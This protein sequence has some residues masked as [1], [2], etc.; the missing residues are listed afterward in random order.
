MFILLKR[1]N[2]WTLQ[3]LRCC[4]LFGKQGRNLITIK[5]A[6]KSEQFDSVEPHSGTTSIILLAR[7]TG[8]IMP[9]ES[10]SV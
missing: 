1:K 2:L 10:F 7:N 5:P 9:R 8:I 4:R 6:T 3:L